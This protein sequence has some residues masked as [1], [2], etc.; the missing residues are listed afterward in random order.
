MIDPKT[1]CCS[2]RCLAQ[3]SVLPFVGVL[4]LLA[5]VVPAGFGYGALTLSSLGGAC[6]IG[7]VLGAG[8]GSLFGFNYP[9][10]FNSLAHR[11]ADILS[12][13]TPC[14]GNRNLCLRRPSLKSSRR[15]Q[16][17]RVAS[18]SRAGAGKLP[19]SVVRRRRAR[20]R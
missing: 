2:R 3:R 4:S 1:H 16:Q 8:M 13:R 19:W 12:G 15:R 18:E 14:A 7:G 10:M 11:S 20:C 9:V 6:T 5:G 17:N